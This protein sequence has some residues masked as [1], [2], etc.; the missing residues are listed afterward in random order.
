MM[1][2]DIYIYYYNK[3]N[4]KVTWNMNEIQ[5]FKLIAANMYCSLCVRQCFRHISS[6]VSFNPHSNLSKWMVIRFH[7]A[8]AEPRNREVK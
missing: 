6:I 8:E 7:V 5:Y 4:I 2:I 3:E 1:N